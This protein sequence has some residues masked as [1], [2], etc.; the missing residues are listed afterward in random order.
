MLDAEVKYNIFSMNLHLQL[1][2]MKNTESF[3][4]GEWSQWQ[5]C[6]ATCGEGTRKRFRFCYAGNQ[7]SN[8]V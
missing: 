4:W 6:S 2:S 8:F 5:A 3:K 7:F 1:E